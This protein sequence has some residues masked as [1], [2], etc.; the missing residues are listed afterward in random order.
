MDAAAHLLWQL[1]AG[2]GAA[3]IAQPVARAYAGG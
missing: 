1:E 3:A 2:D